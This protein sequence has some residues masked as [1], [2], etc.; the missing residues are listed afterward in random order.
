MIWIVLPAYNEEASLP[1]LLPKIDAALKARDREYR[2]VVVND[3][4]TDRTAAI[5]DEI[6]KTQAMDVITHPLNRGLGETERDG[7][8]FVAARSAAGDVI[9]RVEGDD[10]HDPQYIFTLMAKLDEGFDV[11]NTSRFQPGGSQ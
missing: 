8:E 4:S 11:V 9:V 3:G 2:L 6:G 5:L 1:K 10:T 7:F